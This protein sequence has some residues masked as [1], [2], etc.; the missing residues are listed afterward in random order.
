MT[1]DAPRQAGNRESAGTEQ[2]A[3]DLGIKCQDMV[4]SG[5]NAF[6]AAAVQQAEGCGGSLHAAELEGLRDEF[7]SN[8]ENLAGPCDRFLANILRSSANGRS[9]PFHR[10]IVSRFEHMLAAPGV[11]RQAGNGHLP[12]RFLPGFFLAMDKMLG[13]DRIARYEGQCTGIIKRLQTERGQ[14]FSWADVYADGEANRLVIDPLVEIAVLFDNLES[15]AAWFV[16][17]VNSHLG[18]ESDRAQHHDSG[19]WRLT[20]WTLQRLLRNMFSDLDSAFRDETL[21]AYIAERFG[22]RTCSTVENVLGRIREISD[23]DVHTN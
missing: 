13:E 12:R 8:V 10:L 16:D 17:L 22:K 23:E 2:L 21:R 3:S 7:L 19:D 14:A 1:G 6:V 15:R 20:D 11:G 4:R 18:D 5:I 9:K